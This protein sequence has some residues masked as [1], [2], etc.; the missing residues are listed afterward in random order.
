VALGG[1]LANTKTRIRQ[2]KKEG[3]KNR[4]SQCKGGGQILREE[5]I[6]R[7]EEV[8]DDHKQN[9]KENQSQKR[10]YYNAKFT[11]GG[12]KSLAKKFPR[13]GRNNQIKN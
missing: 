5:G 12:K 7:F 11:N 6:G 8:V 4:G 13:T 2:K 1:A 10:I 9:K 3:K